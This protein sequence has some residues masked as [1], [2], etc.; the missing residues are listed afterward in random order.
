MTDYRVKKLKSL[1]KKAQGLIDEL[2]LLLDAELRHI[3]E[4]ANC[5]ELCM[6]LSEADKNLRLAV[7]DLQNA[8]AEAELEDVQDNMQ[9]SM[10]QL[11]G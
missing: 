7:Y 4:Y 11:A 10:E 6:Q 1:T 5:E 8:E 2:D 3:N 9:Q